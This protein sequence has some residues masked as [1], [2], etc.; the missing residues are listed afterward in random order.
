MRIA[1]SF[2]RRA[3]TVLAALTLAF[4]PPV[5]QASRDF[6]SSHAASVTDDAHDHH[7][8]ANARDLHKHSHSHDRSAPD[9]SHESGSGLAMYQEIPQ[10][11]KG[12][13]AAIASD[14]VHGRTSHPPERPPRLILR[15]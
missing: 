6:L 7:G 10:R 1:A 9:H 4:A 13:W 12:G 5:A 14:Y 2:V 8:D 11:V 3:M 15:A